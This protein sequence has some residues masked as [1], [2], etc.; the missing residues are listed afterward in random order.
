MQNNMKNP[1]KNYHKTAKRAANDWEGDFLNGTQSWKN[2][3]LLK[4]EFIW[5]PLDFST[6]LQWAQQIF[7]W[8]QEWI[9]L[10]IL[11]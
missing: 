8:A 7:I 2:A 3:E 5:P 4:N 11:P 9:S 1:K 10:T 6:F